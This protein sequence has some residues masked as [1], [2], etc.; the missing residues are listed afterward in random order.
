MAGRCPLNDEE[1]QALKD[2]TGINFWELNGYWRKLSAQ[3]SFERPKESPCLDKIRDDREKF[4]KAVAIIAKGGRRLKET[5]R[6]DMKGFV[7]CERQQEMLRKYADRLQVE[8]AN[9]EAIQK[10][11][12]KYDR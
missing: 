9:N 5:P 3:V 8:A 1:L 10:G 11:D 6:A 7:P 2:L 4:D 12:K